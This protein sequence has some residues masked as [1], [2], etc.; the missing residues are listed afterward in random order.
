MHR[1]GSIHDVAGDVFH[2]GPS[3]SG[4]RNSLTIN[5]RT[6]GFT[7]ASLG[8]LQYQGESGSIT[9]GTPMSMTS[10]MSPAPTHLTRGTSFNG[11]NHGAGH[12]QH[13]SGSVQSHVLTRHLTSPSIG[14]SVQGDGNEDAARAFILQAIE[15]A[16][17]D[18][19][20]VG[21]FSVGIFFSF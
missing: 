1:T 20:K 19:L 15:A 4:K 7:N 16:N 11:S 13:P 18:H 10:P 12:Q 9:A 8:S 6:R 21:D 5:T 17:S 14:D 3:T 2:H